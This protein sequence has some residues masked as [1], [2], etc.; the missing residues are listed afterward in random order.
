MKA[1]EFVEAMKQA[2]RMCMT[3]LGDCCRHCPLL[4]DE[5][6][7]M[8][9]FSEKSFDTQAVQKLENVIMDWAKQ[10]PELVYPSWR[11][12]WKQFCPEAMAIPC[13]KAFGVKCENSVCS[14]CLN[15]PMTAEVAEKLG[16][17]PIVKEGK[18]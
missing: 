18:S 16:I 5:N 13:P 2:H 11:D 10:N 9:A 12:G 8:D 3:Y 6:C 17:K 1:M 14:Y 4:Q 15:Q 7:T